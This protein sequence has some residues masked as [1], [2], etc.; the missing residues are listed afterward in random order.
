M[1]DFRHVSELII[2]WDVYLIDYKQIGS[3]RAKRL[4]N[5]IE[6][7]WRC[8][9]RWHVLPVLIYPEKKGLKLD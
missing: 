7:K 9:K 3:Y 2:S 5:C 1:V 6:F 8:K 4:I